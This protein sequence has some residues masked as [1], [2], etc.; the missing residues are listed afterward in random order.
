MGC[1]KDKSM[2]VPQEFLWPGRHLIGE[3]ILKQKY[4]G[5]TAENEGSLIFEVL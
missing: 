3:R 5:W 4:F 2:V 1:L